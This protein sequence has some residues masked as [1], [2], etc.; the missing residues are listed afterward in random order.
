MEHQP[1]L[2]LDVPPSN[3]RFIEGGRAIAARNVQ[4]SFAVDTDAVS[5]NLGGMAGYYVVAWDD[6][7]TMITAYHC[8]TRNPYSVAMLPD[9]LRG[10]IASD[11]LNGEPA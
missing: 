2:P 6:E 4:A 3:L 11:V 7:G 10:R 1:Q 5:S 9:L 8:G